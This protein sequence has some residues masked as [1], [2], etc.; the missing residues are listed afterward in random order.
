MR[1][2][3]YGLER[4]IYVKLEDLDVLLFLSFFFFFFFIFFIFFRF[5]FL[6]NKEW[7][8]SFVLFNGIGFST[9]QYSLMFT[10][11]DIRSFIRCFLLII[12]N[13]LLRCS[14]VFILYFISLS[15]L[16]SLPAFFVF[17]Y[18]WK[19]PLSYCF[20]CIVAEF[21]WGTWTYFSR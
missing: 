10:R 19:T 15:I 16:F 13:N 18:N 12:F 2:V 4:P 1:I 17:L 3:A 14:M 7:L 11:L 21:E 6:D 8:F 9:R 20:K 5:S